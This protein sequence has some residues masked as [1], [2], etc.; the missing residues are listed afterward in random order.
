MAKKM[1]KMGVFIFAM[2]NV[3]IVLSLRGLPLIAKT[4]MH[5]VFFVL[6]AS[7]LFLL[8]SALVSAELATGWIKDGG[9]Y[10]WTQKAREVR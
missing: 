7:F 5:M 6:F 8:P 4:G 10:R 1:K 3:A 2:M 9:V